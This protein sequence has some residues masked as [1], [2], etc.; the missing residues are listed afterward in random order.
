MGGARRH[1]LVLRNF[2]EVGLGSWKAWMRFAF[3]E[4]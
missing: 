3:W 1:A 2:E 4:R